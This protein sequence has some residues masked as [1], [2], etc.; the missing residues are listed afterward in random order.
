MGRRWFVALTFCMPTSATRRAARRKFCSFAIGTLKRK[1]GEQR[2][3][4]QQAMGAL[5]EQIAGALGQDRFE[6][7]LAALEADWG[8]NVANGG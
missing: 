5:S 3:D 6:N 1:R 4:A 2:Q 7:M 8:S